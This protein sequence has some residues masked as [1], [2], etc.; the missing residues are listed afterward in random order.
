M[1]IQFTGTFFSKNNQSDDVLNR[2]ISQITDMDPEA[3]IISMNTGTELYENAV[4]TK[5]QWRIIRLI[6]AGI[7]LL[8]FVLNESIVIIEK[9][10]NEQGISGVNMAV[11]AYR[12]EVKTAVFLENL[13]ISVG[14]ALFVLLTMKPLAKLFALDNVIVL[15]RMVIIETIFTALVICGILTWCSMRRIKLYQISYMLKI[16]ETE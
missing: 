3:E 13:G 8:F 10:E 4:R 12:T 5:D 1:E 14:A 6:I 15:D 7:A 16:K 2:V 9:I 11:G